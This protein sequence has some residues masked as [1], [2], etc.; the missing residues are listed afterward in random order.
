M[1]RDYFLA[2]AFFHLSLRFWATNRVIQIKLDMMFGTEREDNH[3]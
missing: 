3:D 1:T 2:Y